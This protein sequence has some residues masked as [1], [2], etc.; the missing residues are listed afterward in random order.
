MKMR[1]VIALVIAILLA[2]LL[3]APALSSQEVKLLGCTVPEEAAKKENPSKADAGSIGEGR[4]LFVS[5]CALCHGKAG[6]GK[7]DLVEAMKLKVRDYSDPAVLKDVSDGA[8]FYV[9]QKGCGD[10]P[11]EGGRLKDEQMWNLVNYIRSLAKKTAVAEKKE[12]PPPQ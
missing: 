12:P 11:A 4:R 9:L 6:D 5:Q 1:L 10:M 2:L 8:M 3:A 7:G